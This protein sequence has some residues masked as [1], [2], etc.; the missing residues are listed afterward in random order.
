M[1]NKVILVGNVGQDPEI[2][3][4][5]SGSKIATFSVA[6]TESWKD[7]SSGEKKTLTQWHRIVVF[8]ENISNI[9]E[10]YVKKG[11]K[12]FVEGAIQSRKY[13][14]NDGIEKNITEIVISQFRGEIQLLDS[15]NSDA[16]TG[17]GSQDYSSDNSSSSTS[18]SKASNSG[19]SDNF[20]SVG[21]DLDDEIPF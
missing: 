4:A 20:S 3:F 2:R 6:T 11:S 10:S 15:R 18:K 5:Q 1:V 14:G 9:V 19:S 13:T 16:V 21:D 8:N 7:R 12:V 17:G